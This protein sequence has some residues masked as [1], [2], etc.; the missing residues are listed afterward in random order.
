MEELRRFL[1]ISEAFSTEKFKSGH[2]VE[3]YPKQEDDQTREEMK[4]DKRQM[5]NGK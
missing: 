4:I 3:W 2:R 1:P 5:R